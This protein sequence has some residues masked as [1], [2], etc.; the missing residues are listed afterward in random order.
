MLMLVVVE[1]QRLRR[2]QDLQ[3]FDCSLQF[4]RHNDEG[5]NWFLPWWNIKFVMQYSCKN[6][7]DLR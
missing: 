7:I 2:G 3:E 6:I 1:S 5:K 4:L